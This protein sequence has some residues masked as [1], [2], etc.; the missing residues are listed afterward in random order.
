MGKTFYITAQDIVLNNPY[1]SSPVSFKNKKHNDAIQFQNKVRFFQQTEHVTVVIG[2]FTIN[3][4]QS[5]EILQ[6]GKNGRTLFT[7]QE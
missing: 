4:D 5:G 7:I 1:G 3:L 6:V 2:A